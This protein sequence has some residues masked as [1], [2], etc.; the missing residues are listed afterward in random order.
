MI[1]IGLTGWGDHSDL[2]VSTAKDRLKDY[3][4]HFPVV[5]LDTAFYAIP[6]IKNSSKWIKETPDNFQFVVKAYQEITGH[7][8][9][10]SHYDSMEEMFEHYRESILP[11]KEAGKLSMVLV[12]F[13]PWFTCVKENVEYILKV[14]EELKD[15]ELAIEFRHQSWYSSKLQNGT[16]D[17]LKSHHLHHTVCDEPQ[18]GEGSVPLIPI[19]TSEK[20]LVRLHGRN[21]YGWKNPGNNEKWREVRYLYDYNKEELTSIQNKVEQL[22]KQAK[23]VVVLFNNNS[24]GH[25]AKNAKSFQKMLGIEFEGLAPKQLDLFEG[26]I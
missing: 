8:R 22:Q 7:L 19:A 14:K 18:V 15:F 24:G 12:Q 17:F 10:E 3:S 2:Y 16:L 1:K 25:A 23:E 13:P 6:S 5:E 21:T 9:G 4:A 20:V 26:G 11:F